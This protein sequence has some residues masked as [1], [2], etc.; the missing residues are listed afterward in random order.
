MIRLL[1]VDD[2]PLVR[3]GLKRTLSSMVGVVVIGEAATGEEAVERAAD[4]QPDI[5]IMD[6]SLPHMSGIDATRMIKARSPETSILVLT[7]HAEEIYIRRAI[8][9]GASGYLS[10]DARPSDLVEAIQAVQRGEQ[11]LMVASTQNPARRH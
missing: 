8:E 5:V 11:Y 2:H 1:L 6:L 3:E 10:K 7:M 9:A 4:L